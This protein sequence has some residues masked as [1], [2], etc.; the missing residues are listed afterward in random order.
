[1]TKRLLIIS[2]TMALSCLA[3]LALHAAPVYMAG[4]ME[5]ALE[6]EASVVYSDGILR[7]NGCEGKTLEIVSI[8]GKKVMEVK[9]ESPAQEI[10]LNI[11]RGCYIVKV[12]KIVHKV[13]IH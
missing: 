1:M 12:A 7:V 3:P 9:I 2:L 10:K 13:S 8:T 11:P 4:V 5:M 6:P